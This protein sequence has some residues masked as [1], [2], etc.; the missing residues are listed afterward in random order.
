MG[1]WHIFRLHDVSVA[2]YYAFR[3][4][5]ISTDQRWDRLLDKLDGKELTPDSEAMVLSGSRRLSILRSMFASMICATLS[6]PWP[7]PVAWM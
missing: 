7:S 6:P 1:G 4:Q 5:N 3:K 2:A